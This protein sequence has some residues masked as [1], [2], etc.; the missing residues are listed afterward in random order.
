MKISTVRKLSVFMV[1]CVL[2]FTASPAFSQGI[3]KAKAKGKEK[4]EA[5]GKHGRE[6]GEMPYGLE[7]YMETKEGELPSG[8]QN[9]EDAYGRLTRGLEKGG[10]DLKATSKGKKG[11]K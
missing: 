9:K 10:K 5:Y 4:T 6:A 1:I 3:G 2:G 8:L 11:S 7:R